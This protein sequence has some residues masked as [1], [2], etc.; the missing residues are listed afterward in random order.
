VDGGRNGTSAMVKWRAEQQVALPQI[1][2]IEVAQ[3]I[4]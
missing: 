3:I 2:M 4:H 1:M